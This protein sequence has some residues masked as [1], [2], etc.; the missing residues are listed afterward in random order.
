M[1]NTQQQPLPQQLTFRLSLDD[2]ATFKNFFCGAHDSVNSRVVQLLEDGLQRWVFQTRDKA[3]SGTLLE[4]F[5]WL[6][7]SRGVGCSHLLQ[8]VC[9]EAELMGVRAFYLDFSRHTALH[10]DILLGLES[11]ALVCLDA[12]DELAGQPEW[13]MALFNLYNRMSESQT[14][15][16]IGAHST[17]QQLAFNLP[18]L[19]SR[20]QSAV[21]FHLEILSDEEKVVALKLRADCRGFELSDEVARFLVARSERSMTQLLL[22][23]ALLDKHSLSTQRK[24][25]IPLLKSVMGW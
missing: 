13:E 9:H 16:L 25:T 8:A 23:L 6:W 12:I 22:V 1:I 14:P 21:L 10:P 11:M 19:T 4:E 24:V 2:D 7:G 17:P 18:D 20:M 5:F 3:R 15:L